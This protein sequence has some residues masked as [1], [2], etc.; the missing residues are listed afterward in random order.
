M[1]T[2]KLNRLRRRATL[3]TSLFDAIVAELTKINA[4]LHAHVAKIDADMVALVAAK[5]TALKHIM[6][7]D[8]VLTHVS[9][10]TLPHDEE[11]GAAS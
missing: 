4:K 7:N 2:R 9:K 11:T 6:D 1:C 3:I 5:E 8:L 10:L